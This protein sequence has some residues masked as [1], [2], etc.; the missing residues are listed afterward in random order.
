MQFIVAAADPAQRRA[1]RAELLASGLASDSE[2]ES[3]EQLQRLFAERVDLADESAHE[4]VVVVAD[5]VEER[6]QFMQPALARSIPVLVVP[7]GA[8]PYQPGQAK[9]QPRRLRS[10][11]STARLT[12]RERQVLGLVA[13]GVANKGIARA[14]GVSPNTVKFHLSA[15]FDKLGVR[16]RAE[17]IA[18]AARA[19]EIAL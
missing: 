4:V 18:A 8:A 3:P 19:G 17:A 9:A 2:I 7:L 14:L 1:L 11:R 5:G 16:T 12:G 10:H 6:T 13:A 15:L